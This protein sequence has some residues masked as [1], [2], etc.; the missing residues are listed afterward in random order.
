MRRVETQHGAAPELEG[1]L[2]AGIDL[3]AGLRDEDQ[4]NAAGPGA[5]GDVEPRCALVEQRFDAPAPLPVCSVVLVELTGVRVA[6]PA[7]PVQHHVARPVADA[8]C[9]PG[10][11]VVVLRDRILD[12][13]GA[14]CPADVLPV[15]LPRIGRELGRVDA[16]D[17]EPAVAVLPVEIDEGRQAARAVAAGVDPEV[18]QHHAAPQVL[19]PE[20]AV[21]VEPAVVGELWSDSTGVEVRRGR[22]GGSPG[23]PGGQRRPMD[24]E[25]E[26]D[27]DRD[28]E[29][30]REAA[31]GSQEIRTGGRRRMWHAGLATADQALSLLR[32]SAA[33]RSS[34]IAATSERSLSSATDAGC[35]EKGRPER[36]DSM[37]INCL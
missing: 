36:P 29:E 31:H 17:R 4:T 11:A 13:V 20:R 32:E 19:E 10:A 15:V 5:R 7:A 6:D 35:D 3:S 34:T 23:Q 18:E 37:L 16:D 8:V 22:R 30:Q 25:A 9:V 24:P 2:Q 14:Q 21:G 28:N 12:A 27:G 33:S 1:R 26:R